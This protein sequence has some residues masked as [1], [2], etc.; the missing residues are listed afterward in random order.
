MRHRKKGD[1]CCCSDIF[2]DRCREGQVRDA[3]E[4]GIDLGELRADK[5]SVC[6]H[7]QLEG[8]MAEKKP[9]SFDACITSSTYDAGT[10]ALGHPQHLIFP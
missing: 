6:C 3:G 5:L 9:H 8:R 7:R 1:I 2:C 10:Y 4:A